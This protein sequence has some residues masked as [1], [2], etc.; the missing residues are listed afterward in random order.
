MQLAYAR[1]ADRIW[2][3]NVGDLKP[4]E[5]P[6]NHFLDL[7]YDIS[8]WGYGSVPR[9]LELWA[10]REFGTH[11]A[12]QIASLTDRYGVL[13]ARRKYE[14]L[15]PS[16][17]S[18]INYDEANAILAEWAELAK[19]AQSIYDRLDPIAQIAFFEMVLHPAL[20]GYTVYQIHIGA[21]V[22]QL[23]VAQRRTSANKEAQSVLKSFSQDAN[24]T[25]MY[26]NLLK[27]KVKSS[28]WTFR[29]IND[30]R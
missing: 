12:A 11:E 18:V 25:Q 10:T 29:T 13:A 7:A 6:I 24:I 26:H 14:V 8:K 4:L 15:S 30:I 17:Y 3:V 2:I 9:W 21:A 20:A 22:N 1:K 5:V 27:G 16:V 19:D 28:R 23:Y